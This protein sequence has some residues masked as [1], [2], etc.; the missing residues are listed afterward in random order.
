M[1]LAI[2][3]P[4]EPSGHSTSFLWFASWMDVFCCGV[5]VSCVVDILVLTVVEFELEVVVVEMVV[6]VDGLTVVISHSTLQGQS[7]T[8]NSE[9]KYNLPDVVI[10]H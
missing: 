1:G 7:Q 10:G 8:C 4:L 6:V 2:L 5:V 3:C 9:S